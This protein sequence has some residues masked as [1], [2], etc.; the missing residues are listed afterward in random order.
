MDELMNFK[1]D[2]NRVIGN[3]KNKD[4]YVNNNR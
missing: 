1:I 2:D 3:S 4:Q